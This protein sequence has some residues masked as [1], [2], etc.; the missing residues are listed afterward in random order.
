[1][2]PT[3]SYHSDFRLK[4]LNILLLSQFFSSTRG[5]GEHLFYIMAKKLAENNHQVWII[6]NKIEDENYLVHKNIKIVF[7]PPVL[8][9]QGGLPPSIKDNIQYLINAVKVGRKI[10]KEN[11]IEIIHSNNFTPSFVGGVLSFLTSRVHVTSVWD[12][13][14]LCGCDYWKKWACQS[15]VVGSNA[16]FSFLTL[17]FSFPYISDEDA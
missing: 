1:M 15:G 5:G 17:D 11:N 6:T 13:F 2:I 7:V 16:V 10:V 14:T 12:I 9:Y 3:S 4:I 8:K